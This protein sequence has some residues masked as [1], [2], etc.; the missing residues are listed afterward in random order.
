MARPHPDKMTFLEHLDELRQRLV[1]VALYLA[2]GFAVCWGFHEQIFHFLTQPLRRAGFT[3][4]FIYTSP[5]E[6]FLLY[7]KMAFFVGIFVASPFVLWEIWAFISPGLYRNEKAWAVPFI[8][9]GSL[10]FASGAL[11]GHYVLFPMTFRFLWGFGGPD[12]RFLPRIGEYW[13]FYS[14]FLLGLGAV[15]QIPV[16]IFVLARIGLVSAGLLLRAWKW[17]VLGAFVISAVITPSADVVTQTTLAGPMIGLYL[18]G[19]AVAWLFGRERRRETTAVR[20][21]ARS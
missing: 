15:F 18:L 10:F 14:W 3:D 17:A 6:A 20:A 2:G 21:A 8:G 7:M 19:V 5:A 9:M 4:Q 12:M 1:R 11:F 16:V 13:S